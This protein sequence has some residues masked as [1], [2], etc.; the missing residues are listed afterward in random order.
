MPPDPAPRELQTW[1]EIAAYLK[2]SIRSA[3]QYEKTAGLPVHRMA[4]KRSLVWAVPAELDVW[5]RRTEPQE[6]RQAPPRRWFAIWGGVALMLTLSGVL[7]SLHLHS[8]IPSRLHIAGKVL[9]VLDDQGEQLWRYT[10]PEEMSL[11]LLASGSDNRR[12]QFLDIDGDGEIELLFVY[13]KVDGTTPGSALYC[14][15]RS[16]NVKWKYSPQRVLMDAMQSVPPVYTIASVEAVPPSSHGPGWIA[17]NGQHGWSYPNIVAVLNADGSVQGEY[18]HS[19]HLAT[20]HLLDLDG[21]GVPEIVL[22]GIAEGYN[23]A[24]LVVLDHRRVF[25]VSTQPSH[26]HHQLQGL[27]TGAEKAVVMFPG[28]CFTKTLETHNRT[29]S[30]SAS[31]GNLLAFVAEAV[32]D[33]KPLPYI[34]YQLSHS[35]ALQNA[36]ISDQFVTRH[37]ELEAQHLLD[38]HYTAEACV[39]LKEYTLLRK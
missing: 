35:L 30:V 8:R 22:G 10:F 15:S 14:F 16:G 13:D 7:W 19:G 20:M 38:H 21:D 37:H 29:Y 1:Q 34:V 12:S 31:G 18:W 27:P 25:G 17:T 2:V 33:P 9:T 6:A 11:G 23:R 39:P 28:S 32:S 3:Q 26:D 4:G 36:T 5:K 24:T